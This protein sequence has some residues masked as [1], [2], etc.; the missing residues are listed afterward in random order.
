MIVSMGMLFLLVPNTIHAQCW[1][2]KGADLPGN[3]EYENI[4]TSTCMS[5]DGHTVA[6]GA[7]QYGNLF[8]RVIVHSWNG[9][10]W[11]QKGTDLVGLIS[12]ER[13]GTSVD[14]TAD[15]NLLA[16]G[17]RTNSVSAATSGAVRMYEWNNN[18]WQQ[19][20]GTIYGDLSGQ[21]LGQ[22]IDI[23]D[24][25]STVAIGAPFR[26]L[27]LNA[28]ETIGLVR[29]YHWNDTLNDW[30]QLGSDLT[31]IQDGDWFGRSVSLSADGSRLAVGANYSSAFGGYAGY[32]RVFALDNGDWLLEHTFEGSNEEGLGSDVD[33]TPDGNTLVIGANSNNDDY[34]L[35]GKAY[36]YHY[37]NTNQWEPRGSISGETSNCFLGESVAISDDGDIVVAG[38]RRSANSVQWTDKGYMAAYYW[39][40]GDQWEQIGDDVEGSMDQDLFG[41]FVAIS[42]DGNTIAGGAKQFD[43]NVSNVGLVRVYESCLASL[44]ETDALS[45]QFYPNP[46]TGIVETDLGAFHQSVTIKVKNTLGQTVR[47]L[48]TSGQQLSVTLPETPGTYFI[49]ITTE[50]GTSISKIIK[51]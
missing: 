2:Q 7:P 11:V 23:S 19:K 42:G 4:G 5:N 15:G 45:L 1:Q 41:E 44:T 26:S 43:G 20:G 38:G 39:Q 17:A 37:N 27:G 34:L 10:A 6:S 49:E 33:L 47:E 18:D 9:N 14:I 50:R 29:V 13:F 48:E 16:I 25:G 21:G 8:G 24:D 36:V 22:Y 31:G 40:G 12:S 51:Q 3:E 46:S 30:E 35:A 28:W 32:A